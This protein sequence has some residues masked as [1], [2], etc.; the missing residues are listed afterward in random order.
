ASLHPDRLIVKWP[1]EKVGVACLLEEIGRH[2]RFKRARAHPS[3]R[4]YADM[5]LDDLRALLDGAPLV[6]LPHAAEQ[7]G[8]RASMS[9]HVI[10]ACPD[11]LDDFRII[12]ADGAVEQ[13]RGR[14]LQ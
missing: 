10:A 1:I 3:G 6:V 4:P 7:F 8:V 2:V 9:N 14:K 13:D 5:F 12:V 11:L